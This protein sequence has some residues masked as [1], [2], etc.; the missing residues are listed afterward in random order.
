MAEK[1]NKSCYGAESDG[2]VGQEA[3]M[4]ISTEHR[5]CYSLTRSNVP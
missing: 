2:H 5:K 1:D 4:N 3:K